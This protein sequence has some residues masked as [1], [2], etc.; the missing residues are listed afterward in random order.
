MELSKEEMAF[1]YEF[2]VLVT[3]KGTENMKRYI[4]LIEKIEKFLRENQ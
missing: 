2:M 1:I 3:V 4:T